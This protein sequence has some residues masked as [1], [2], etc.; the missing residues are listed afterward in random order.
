MPPSCETTCPTKL[1][2]AC[3]ERTGRKAQIRHFAQN[4]ANCGEL[5]AEN[6]EIRI[7]ETVID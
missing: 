4:P 2:W 1:F 7:T 6:S 3:P 5:S